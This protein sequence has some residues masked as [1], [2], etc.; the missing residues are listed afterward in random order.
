MSTTQTTTHNKPNN[1]PNNKHN[2]HYKTQFYGKSIFDGSPTLVLNRYRVPK[3][4]KQAVS[5]VLKAFHNGV[6]FNQAV[7]KVAA[8]DPDHI[9]RN[10]LAEHTLKT[11]ANDY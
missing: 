1:K 10:K 4:Y 11:I 2:R 8:L 9:N 5:D 7:D 3:A 6:P